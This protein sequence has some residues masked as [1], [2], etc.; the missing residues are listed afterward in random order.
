MYIIPTITV[1]HNMTI[2]DRWFSTNFAHCWYTS[3]A[4]SNFCFLIFQWESKKPVD[5]TKKSKPVQSLGYKKK[6]RRYEQKIMYLACS[7]HLA[8]SCKN[9]RQIS[10]TEFKKRL[11]LD[12]KDFQYI[13]PIHWPYFF[14]NLCRWTNRSSHASYCWWFRNPAITS[15]GW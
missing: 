6:R 15:W 5:Q 7:F 3:L 2:S 10:F 12:P 11:P 4:F 8:R 9:L 1:Q 14:R 13:L